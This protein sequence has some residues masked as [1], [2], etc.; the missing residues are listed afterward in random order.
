MNRI[1]QTEGS[2]QCGGARRFYSLSRCRV[3]SSPRSTRMH[4]QVSSHQTMF[5]VSTAS[6]RL[7]LALLALRFPEC[8]PAR[9][10]AAQ[11]LLWGT[12][13]AFCY[14]TLPTSTSTL[15][16]PTPATKSFFPVRFERVLSVYSRTSASPQFSSKVSA[17]D[18]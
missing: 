16:H 17:S 1:P 3:A 9:C 11:T 6:T 5:N 18:A 7:S 12:V 13:R 8:R 14:K 2:E 10:C 15:R 4:M